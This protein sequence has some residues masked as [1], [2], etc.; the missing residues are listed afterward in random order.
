MHSVYRGVHHFNIEESSV[1]FPSLLRK[2]ANHVQDINTY[3]IDD[4]SFIVCDL[5]GA[6]PFLVP[7]DREKGNAFKLEVDK[8]R[9]ALFLVMS[10]YGIEMEGVSSRVHKEYLL[11]CADISNWRSK[12]KREAIL[13]FERSYEA[14]AEV[15]QDRD[16]LLRVLPVII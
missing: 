16:T 8:R 11:N 14:L 2:G 1:H 7:F 5:L 9:E 15:V 6:D 13:F 10:V 4:G 12:N 3:D